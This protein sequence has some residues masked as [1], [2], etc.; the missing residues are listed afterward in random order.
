MSPPGARERD[1]YFRK[2]LE[3]LAGHLH[4]QLFEECVQDI[5]REAF[6]GLVAIHGGSDAG[7][8][9]AAVPE[10]ENHLLVV[11]TSDRVA[12]NLVASLK[13]NLAYG[14]APSRV[15]VATSALLS[16]A[17]RRDLE[18]TAKELGF[19]LFGKIFDRRDIAS[20]L[21]RDSRWTKMLLGITGEPPALSTFP[22][23]RRDLPEVELVGRNED[24]AWLRAGSG[25]RLIV[26][27]PGSGKTSLLLELVKERRALFLATE[28]EG[29]F[30]E[31]YRD[32][33][34]EIVLVD[35]AHLDPDQLDRLRQVRR[36][37][38][39]EDAFAVVATS[40]KGDWEQVADALGRISGD[41][42]RRLDLLTP[43]EILEV[44]RRIGVQAPDDDP[45]LA[46]LVGQ[47]AGRPGLAVTLGTLSLRGGYREV[48]TGRAL[49]RSL[50]SPLRRILEQDP[51]QLLAGFALGGRRGMG[52]AAMAEF[53]E[54]EIGKVWETA[55]Q[56]GASGVLSERGKDDTGEAVLAVIPATLR[57]ALLHEVFFSSPRR[58]WE[59]H[60]RRSQSLP[61]AIE[62]LVFAAHRTVPVPRSDLQR[63]LLEAGSPEAWQSFTSLGEAE[64]AWALEHYPGPTH[65]IAAQALETVPERATRRLLKEAE[66]VTNAGDLRGGKPLQILREWIEEIPAGHDGVSDALQRRRHL[67]DAA[68]ER[69]DEGGDSGVSLRAVLLALSP[70]LE[71]TRI[72]AT[73]GALIMRHASLP[74]SAAPEM[75]KIWKRVRGAILNLGLDLDRW[76]ELAQALHWWLYPNVASK[77]GEEGELE[78]FHRVARQILKDL[79][80]FATGRPG[81][82]STLLERAADVALD[83]DLAIDPAFE[84]LYPR[85]PGTSPG[86]DLEPVR[87]ARQEAREAARKLAKSWAEREPEIILADLAH[88]AAE[89]RWRRGSLGTLPDFEE[90]LVRSADRPERWLSAVLKT[91]GHLSLGGAFLYRVVEE[92]RTGWEELVGRC[93][94]TRE[95]S[96]AASMRV[97]RLSQPPQELLD[98]ALD[99]AEPQAV[100]TA[101]L[102]GGVPTTTLRRLLAHQDPRV[103]LAAAIGEWLAEPRQSV[104]AEVQQEWRN[105]ILSVQEGEL[106]DRADEELWLQEI[107]LHAPDLAFDW[108]RA[109]LSGD[110]GRSP[111]LVHGPSPASTAIRALDSSRRTRLLQ[112]LSAESFS[113]S[114]VSHLV[115]ESP[116]LYRK[117]LSR[118]DL[119]K[120]HLAPLAGKPPDDPWIALARIALDAGYPPQEVAEV[121]FHPFHA[122]SPTVEHY[123]KWETAF[124]ALSTA[125]DPGLTEVAHHGLRQALRLVSEAREE[126]RQFELTGRL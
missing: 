18:E 122:F 69:L 6:P 68:L 98:L 73:G 59:Q 25:D 38:H 7:M 113:D 60:L 1:P 93:L 123:T 118:S 76:R 80:P 78:A 61:S 63:L 16:P 94:R 39:A 43:T 23:T 48:L 95:Y 10:G 101:C 44:L 41:R 56:I 124:R 49:Y 96:W 105:V 4:P 126:E 42:V 64:G 87:K 74:A 104:R 46:E 71:T 79:V 45:Y 125:T 110:E 117:L 120:H 32:Q 116:D 17:D 111:L 106:R 121:A 86:L 108:L 65:E 54:A 99:M 52:L 30:A 51:T 107:L 75:L 83:L 20:R 21:C 53:L 70:R 84:I 67:V 19:E 77:G 15:V 27:E 34:P 36:D 97:L 90:A 2:I 8:D 47:A 57:A 91:R 26:G 89:A 31:A 92:R 82:A 14:Y 109:Q 85:S 115:G 3:G 24:L 11:T 28:D 58:A 112:E 62:T 103:A 119:S 72:A 35:D 12:R 22:R 88:Y 102:Q 81:L 55:A 5:L 37:I 33:R 40:W 50:V 29:R 100:K 9:G 66:E 13:S 114:L